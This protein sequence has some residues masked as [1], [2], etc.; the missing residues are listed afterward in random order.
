MV[1]GSLESLPQ[2]ET[3]YQDSRMITATKQSLRTVNK[4]QNHYCVMSVK[5]AKLSFRERLQD[6]RLN[7]GVLG[8]LHMTTPRAAGNL[9]PQVNKFVTSGNCNEAITSSVVLWYV[10]HW[11]KTLLTQ[12]K[13]IKLSG[14]NL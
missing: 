4:E 10:N 11:S 6:N 8:R 3:E 1:D 14:S 5:T 7:V 12:K 13:A 2:A 9:A